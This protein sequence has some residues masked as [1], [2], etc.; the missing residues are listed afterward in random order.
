M[1]DDW[2]SPWWQA[3]LLPD[4]WD[5]AG[6][7][8][9]SL[10]VWHVFALTTLGN[11]F[12]CGGRA[13]T[14]DDAQ[15]LL[16]I[17]ARDYSRGRRLFL[18]PNACARAIRATYRR[19]ARQDQAFTLR[20]C[21]EYT[22]TCMRHG[23]RLPPQGGSG[24]PAGTPEPWSVYVSLRG[25]GETEC[26]AWNTAYAKGRATMDARD[27][28]AGAATMA[29][30]DYGEYMFDHWDEIKTQTGMREVVLN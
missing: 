1:R 18:R 29:P 15:S 5:V 13:P 25:L 20:A 24:T 10:S 9:P 8:V 17:A 6:V 26:S 14:M 4:E 23:H 30:G 21:A 28:R 2:V 3:L 7:R 12:M 27:E 22:E 11:A 16:M 19:L